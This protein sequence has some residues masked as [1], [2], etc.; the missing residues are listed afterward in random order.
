MILIEGYPS[1]RWGD[2]GGL[3]RNFLQ[4]GLLGGLWLLLREGLCV[5]LEGSGAMCKGCG[6]LDKRFEA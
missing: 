4:E 1:F 3:S 6:L 5:G 2:F